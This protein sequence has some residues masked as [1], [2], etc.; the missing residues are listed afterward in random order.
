MRW[1]HTEAVPAMEPLSVYLTVDDRVDVVHC[2]KGWT[3]EQV[4]AATPHYSC[5]HRRT[6]YDK[7]CRASAN[8][9]RPS[10]SP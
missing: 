8:T 6:Q 1:A 10:P 7:M 4:R 2:H 9:L 5:S 3:L